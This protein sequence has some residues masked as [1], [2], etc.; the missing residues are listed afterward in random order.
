MNRRIMSEKHPSKKSHAAKKHGCGKAIVHVDAPK[1][2]IRTRRRVILTPSILFLSVLL[3][4]TLSFVIGWVT[5]LAHT[6]SELG[7]MGL[8][9]PARSP[10]LNKSA[11]SIIPM[12]DSYD[13]NYY[14][15]I[16]QISIDGYENDM[17]P[18]QNNEPSPA[19][20]VPQVVSGKIVPI[21]KYTSKVF[22]TNASAE[23]NTVHIDRI[24]SIGKL[25]DSMPSSTLHSSFPNENHA[26]NSQDANDEEEELHLPAGQ[27]LLID[28]KHVSPSFLNS[29]HSLATSMI[30]LINESE[31]TLLSYHCHSLVPTGISC[32]GVLMESHI[33]FHTWPLLGVIT[34]DLFTCGAKPLIPILGSI[35]RLF[36]IPLTFEE[37]LMM[38]GVDRDSRD[39]NRK[40]L[41]PTMQWAHKLRGFR[42]EFSPNYRR[43]S[44]PLDQEL[45]PDVL[46]RLDL[47]LKEQIV[48]TQTK[49]QHVDIYEL[50]D[51]RIRSLAS[52]QK[53]VATNNDKSSYE[54]PNSELYR[55]DRVLYLGKCFSLNKIAQS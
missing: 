46:G 5:R 29:Q 18:K 22:P 17:A 50:I 42:E 3:S 54:S 39:A 47:D 48:S 11:N 55:T 21:T 19:L 23:S 32:V 51:P 35:E 49:F 2:P 14:G 34:L 26:I 53:P 31:L 36:A 13:E 52:Y 15:I 9:L 27:H 16:K 10:T 6:S 28:I 43:E 30:T 24:N 38:S 45:G 41:S 37:K 4:A 44:N 7:G 20:P 25:S 33:A 12:N 1:H 40:E 8:L